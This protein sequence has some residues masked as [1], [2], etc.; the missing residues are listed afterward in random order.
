M[1]NWECGIKRRWGDWESG[2][3]GSKE[4]GIGIRRGPKETGLSSSPRLGRDKVA[5]QACGSYSFQV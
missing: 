3:E 4:G 1:W 5:R 2:R